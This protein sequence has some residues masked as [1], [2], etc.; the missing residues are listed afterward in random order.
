MHQL[1]SDIL[2]TYLIY[3]MHGLQENIY[4]IIFSNITNLLTI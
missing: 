2:F 1:R 3:L 4:K